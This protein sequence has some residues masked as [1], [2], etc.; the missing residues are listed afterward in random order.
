MG[1]QIAVAQLPFQGRIGIRKAKGPAAEILCPVAALTL[2]DNG[3]T[4][5]S[6][7][8]TAFGAHEGAGGSDFYRGTVHGYHPLSLKFFNL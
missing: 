2:F 1:G 4:G 3:I 6:I 8:R 7:K 5:S